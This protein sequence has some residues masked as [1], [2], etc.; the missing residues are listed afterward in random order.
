VE[1]ASASYSDDRD[2]FLAAAPVESA[3]QSA[4]DCR[5]FDHVLLVS[6]QKKTASMHFLAEA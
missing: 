3:G 5:T 6:S 2:F 4:G 1:A